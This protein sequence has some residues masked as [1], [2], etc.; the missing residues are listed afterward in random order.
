MILHYYIVQNFTIAIGPTWCTLT[1][2]STKILHEL[3]NDM[4]CT[5]SCLCVWKRWIYLKNDFTCLPLVSY[6]E[7]CPLS[8]TKQSISWKSIIWT[9]F[10]F[11]NNILMARSCIACSISLPTIASYNGSPYQFLQLT[12]FCS[13]NHQNS[14]RAGEWIDQNYISV[15]GLKVLRISEKWFHT[16]TLSRIPN[17]TPLYVFRKNTNF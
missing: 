15:F 9:L 8:P 6:T 7:F 10:S 14:A 17:F 11:P 12:E 4:L 2:K 3:G 13:E 16:V 1:S 5:S